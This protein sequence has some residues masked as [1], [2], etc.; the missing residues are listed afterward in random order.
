MARETRSKMADVRKR[1]PYV[2]HTRLGYRGEPRAR[3]PEVK[4]LQIVKYK[5][6]GW[7][8]KRVARKVGV[9]DFAVRFIFT[10][11][12]RTG[13]VAL[14][15][16]TGRPP[17][18]ALKLQRRLNELYEDRTLSTAS[19]GVKWLLKHHNLKVDAR[20][21]TAAMQKMGR[22]KYKPQRKPF[23]SKQTRKDR[24]ERA[25]EWLRTSDDLWQRTVFTDEKEFSTDSKRKV[26][27]VL[28]NPA[29]AA[30]DPRRILPRRTATPIVTKVWAAISPRGFIAHTFYDGSLTAKVYK[31]I[32]VQELLPKVK[33]ALPGNLGWI[34][35]QDGA[36]AHTAGIIE[37]FLLEKDID[38]LYWPPHSPDLNLIENTWGKL[39]SKVQAANPR[40]VDQMRAAITAAIEMN[41]EEPQSHY[42]QALYKS[43]PK[44]LKQVIKTG[45]LPTMH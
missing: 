3:I 20:T 15:K 39:D 8:D 43:M 7:P 24:L 23:T 33:K 17:K 45:G 35:R 34:F 5:Q 2:D 31:K 42:F 21:V 16:P 13:S 18:I 4:R 41:A 19:D 27:A 26:E 12:W 38:V 29:T 44:R 25:S 37:D 9:S 10:R 14:K 36:P 30:T 32:L 1:S 28:L 6:R 40:S 11:Y 22:R